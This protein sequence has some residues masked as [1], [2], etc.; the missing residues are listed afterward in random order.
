MAGRLSRKEAEQ[1]KRQGKRMYINDLSLVEI[2]EI[3]EIHLET[4]QRWARQGKWKQEKELH[5]ISISEIKRQML[6][7]FHEMKEGK[8]P[9][10]SADQLSKLAAAFDKLNDKKKALAYMYENYEELSDAIIKDALS[11]RTKK[12]KE[13]KLSIAKYVREKMDLVT[14]KAYKESLHD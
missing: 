6:T 12:V 10:I 7:T 3:L 8:Q 5:S 9:T 14:S 11:E 2:A 1:K 13:E 4:A